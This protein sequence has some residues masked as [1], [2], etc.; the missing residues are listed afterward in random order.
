M[1]KAEP[2]F[3]A[4][5]YLRGSTG[6]LARY[7]RSLVPDVDSRAKLDLDHLK[8]TWADE[9]E[10]FA[11]HYGL[12]P[13]QREAAQKALKDEEAAAEAWFRDTENAKKIRKY[14]DDLAHYQRVL[15]DS[16]ALESDRT[17]A[18]RDRAAAESERQQLVGEIDAMTG[19]LLSQWS[20]ALTD[21]QKQAGPLPKV[22]TQIDWINAG[23]KFGMV[24]VGLSLILGF[25]TRL[26]ALGAVV[27]LAMFYLS[28]P[29]WPGLPAG[30]MSEGHYLYVNKNLI[31][32]LAC[33]VLASLP[34]GHWLGLD[35][36]FF[37]WLR[38]RGQ[39]AESNDRF[40]PS[41]VEPA[42]YGAEK[43]RG[44]SFSRSKR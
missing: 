2:P 5:P 39:A 27:Y 38:R 23:T 26:G 32:L 43:P 28:M 37:G 22:W 10:R 30:P 3:S 33:L 35:A 20:K 42:R 7:F 24:A 15:S 12:T 8:A 31:E 1:E 21:E 14:F 4:E 17:Q 18:H 44:G 40:Y 11:A 6:P 25:C 13:E 36:L 34:S 16:S 19:D 41:A 9:L 29:P